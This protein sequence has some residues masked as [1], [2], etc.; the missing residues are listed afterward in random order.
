MLKFRTQA[1]AEAG[2]SSFRS[3][4]QPPWP[5]KPRPNNRPK[6]SAGSALLIVLI[7]LG[8]SFVMVGSIYSYTSH[9]VRLNQRLNDYYLAVAAAEAATEKVLSQVNSDYTSYGPGYVTSRL[10]YYQTQIPTATEAPDW[11]NFDFMDLSGQANQV[12]GAIYG[13]ERVPARGW[14]IRNLARLSESDAHSGQRAAPQ[15]PRW[16]GWVGVSGHRIHQHP[17]LP[18]RR[19]LQRPPGN[20][21]GSKHDDHRPGPLQHEHLYQPAA[22]L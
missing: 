13:P 8:V 10:S 3:P 2:V 7:L 15:L 18:V 19:F 17:D 9:T 5:V 12:D 16:R 4:A 14:P 22:P 6:S 21:S 20:H 1:M 11:G